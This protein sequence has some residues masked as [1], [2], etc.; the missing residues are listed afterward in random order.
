M[1]TGLTRKDPAEDD[2]RA[3][4]LVEVDQA[5]ARVGSEVE[6][7]G[8]AGAVSDA[9]GVE[10][11][12]HDGEGVRHRGA[13]EH[14]DLLWERRGKIKKKN[15]SSGLGCV[16]ICLVYTWHIKISMRAVFWSGSSAERW[17]TTGK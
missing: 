14:Q 12:F 11:L 7:A 1:G 5:D 9:T 2:G 16:L 4:V 6:A 10:A 15:C 3:F 17:R 13:V 8:F